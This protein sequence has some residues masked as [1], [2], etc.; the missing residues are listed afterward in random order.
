MTPEIKQNN[1]NIDTG[2]V[3]HNEMFVRDFEI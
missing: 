3:M 2:R 1:E